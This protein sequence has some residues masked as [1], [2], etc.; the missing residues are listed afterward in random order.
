MN[1][2]RYCVVLGAAD[3][4]VPAPSA[5]P[6]ATTTLSFA[7]ATAHPQGAEE[8]AGLVVLDRSQLAELRALGGAASTEFMAELV[9]VFLTEGFAEVEL[10][11]AAAAGQDPA[12]MLTA[13]H[14]LKGSAMN[15]G[16]R[17]LAEAADALES[18]ARAGTV[19]GSGPMLQRLS[20]AF[21]QTAA[22]LRIELE[23]A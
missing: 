20:G 19:E 6:E 12:G 22:A 14:R 23:A 4:I 21:E 8:P 1:T 7:P 9:G 16:C 5:E 10:I 11:R 15:L 17:A 2:T 13:A 3:R 18:L